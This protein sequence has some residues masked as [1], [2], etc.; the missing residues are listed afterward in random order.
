MTWSLLSKSSQPGKRVGQWGEAQ[1]C[2]H[3]VTTA[4]IEANRSEYRSCGASRRRTVQ[5][6]TK[7]KNDEGSLG[8][9]YVSQS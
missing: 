8:G 1:N 5:L 3:S 9:C 6:L 7:Q 2:K 4:P